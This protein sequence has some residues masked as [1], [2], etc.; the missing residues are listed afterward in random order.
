[1]TIGPEPM[2]RM[3]LMS[4]RF[5]KFNPEKIRSNLQTRGRL[6]QRQPGRVQL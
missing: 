3:Q 2:M 4:V 6:F 5:G 1:M